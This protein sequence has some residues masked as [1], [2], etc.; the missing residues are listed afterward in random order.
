MSKY[1]MNDDYKQQPELHWFVSFSIVRLCFITDIFSFILV[2]FFFLFVFY[3][4]PLPF[5]SHFII[6]DNFGIV[7]LIQFLHRFNDMF[8]VQFSLDSFILR[9]QLCVAYV[10]WLHMN[11]FCNAEIPISHFGYFTDNLSFL[12]FSV[13][14]I[15]FIMF[16]F[17]HY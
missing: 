10:C 3:V 15:D 11:T 4:V 17:F 7:S 13:K 2:V 6:F 5:I 1:K 8:T 12:T 16:N 14:P 9:N